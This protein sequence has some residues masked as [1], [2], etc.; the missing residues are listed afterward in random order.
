MDSDVLAW[1]SEGQTEPS[2]NLPIRRHLG[3]L[4]SYVD[5]CMEQ[6]TSLT[7]PIEDT[8]EE[9]PHPSPGE[10]VKIIPIG[11]AWQGSSCRGQRTVVET[12]Y[13]GSLFWM[14]NI[15]TWQNKS[16]SQIVTLDCGIVWSAK[17]RFRSAPRAHR[18]NLRQLLHFFRIELEVEANVSEVAMP[19]KT[20]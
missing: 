12:S 16:A 9:G 14:E 1:A 13:F 4:S 10:W 17:L 15:S 8:L 6:E 11:Y 18:S 19:C 3:D 7:L 2:L 5:L 20:D